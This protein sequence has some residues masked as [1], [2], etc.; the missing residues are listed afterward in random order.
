MSY[1]SPISGEEIAQRGIS[2][3]G[4]EKFLEMISQ[5]CDKKIKSLELVQQWMNKEPLS[6]DETINLVH[7]LDADP[8]LKDALLPGK[9]AVLLPQSPD[10]ERVE[11]VSA[12]M[13]Q[14]ANAK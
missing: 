14:E 6:I 5:G 9:D 11:P 10:V 3:S 4:V 1:K 8:G 2:K 12:G 7:F 13:P